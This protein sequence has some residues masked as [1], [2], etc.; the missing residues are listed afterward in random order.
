[1]DRS[2]V[3]RSAGLVGAMTLISRGM[4]FV[5]DVLM[6]GYFGTSM[7]MSAFVVAFR[8]P[9]LFR[10]LFGE[11]ALSAAFIPVFVETREREGEA[12]AWRLARQVFTL[13]GLA[14][15]T[16]VLLGILAATLALQFGGLPPRAV[17][18]LSLLRLLL[19]YLFFICLAAVAMGALNSYHR[20]ALPAAVPWILNAVWVTA[21]LWVSPH[22]GERP[23]E[24]IYGVALSIIVA[25]ALQWG[26]QIPPLMRL[27][28][29]PVPLL[30]S[31]DRRLLR[32]LALMGPA[33]VGRAVT[34]VNVAI[35]TLLA[36]A[37]GEWA[38]AAL[39]FSERLIYLPLGIFA[40]ALSTVLLPLFSGHAARGERDAIRVAVNHALRM[41]MFVMI[42]ASIGLWALSAPIVRMAFEWR[43]FDQDSTA[44]T[45]RALRFYAP[46]LIVFSLGK[47]FVPAFYGLQDTRTPVR[48]GIRTVLLNIALSVL[49]MLTWPLRYK[50]AGIA[51][52]T[53]VS[54]TINGVW[55]ATLLHR[56]L[57]SPGWREIGLSLL[58]TTAAAL[59]MAVAAAA[60]QAW[61]LKQLT[62]AGWS[63]KPAQWAAV[64]A[65]IA[66]G[67]AVFLAAV[68]AMR[69]P[70][71]AD[72]A[73]AIRRRRARSEPPPSAVSPCLP[74]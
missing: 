39:Y 65:A 68:R 44:L 8:V 37:V 33:A 38:A 31:G 19:P 73:D 21:I 22:F 3:I 61:L 18:T 49:F 2:R 42:P 24:R 58:R 12:G 6:A 13:T 54:E 72:I 45:V 34:Q 30:R 20:F 35:D 23:E 15:A 52:A 36:A 50:H 11:G 7:A 47:V 28:F 14:L 32:I 41:L 59:L 57:G 17:L 71:L 5:R 29:R 4:G 56:R 25:G 74:E 64:T 48:V 53:V 27:G 16:I 70:E 60:G 9:N 46:G 66:F 1:M 55:L 69:S 63:V 62:A 26:V 40:T 51:F 43:Q 10:A 67:I